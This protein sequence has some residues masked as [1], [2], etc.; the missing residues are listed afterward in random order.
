MTIQQIKMMLDIPAFAFTQSVDQ[1]GNALSWFTHWDNV[2]RVRVVVHED[3]LSVLGTSD[4][5]AFK[6][7]KRVSQGTGEV[8]TQHVLIQ[9]KETET[10]VRVVVI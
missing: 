8:Y 4:R 3:L 5:L 6:S 9:T 7:E 2:N 1:Q 10:P